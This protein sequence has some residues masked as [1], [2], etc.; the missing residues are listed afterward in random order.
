MIRARTLSTALWCSVMPSV[1]QIIARGAFAKAWA[2]S[3]MA[4]AGTPVSRSAY[5]SVYGLDLGLVGLE[6]VVARSMNS[7]FSSPASMI[8]RAIALARAMSEPTSR[9]SQRIGPFRR[10]RPARVDRVEPGAVAD[11]LEQVVEE[12]RVRLAGVAA[13][14]DDQVRLFDLTV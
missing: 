2:S 8:S 13:P 12:D 5:S 11:A 4:S 3:R 10:R 14:Q 9:P 6:A 7:R 1:Q